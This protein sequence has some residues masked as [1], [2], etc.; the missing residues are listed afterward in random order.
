[1]DEERLLENPSF[2]DGIDYTNI[3]HTKTR[4]GLI[5]PEWSI[6]D[7]K[8]SKLY[9]LQ[10]HAVEDAARSLGK[11]TRAY[12]FFSDRQALSCDFCPGRAF[13]VTVYQKHQSSH[14]SQHSTCVYCNVSFASW[15]D[16]KSHPSCAWK[17]KVVNT[18][19]HGTIY[20]YCFQQ[21]VRFSTTMLRRIVKEYQSQGDF[22]QVSL[23]GFSKR[24]KNHKKESGRGLHT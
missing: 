12:T 18:N 17:E 8:L 20:F 1:M 9:E 13:A 2:F 19:D 10:G 5:R 14:P 11:S 7:A 16:F 22:V 3:V 24:G 6:R 15:S 4:Q 23:K 21:L